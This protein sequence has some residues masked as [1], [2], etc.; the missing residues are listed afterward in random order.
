MHA[1]LCQRLQASK[2]P[3]FAVS[4]AASCLVHNANHASKEKFSK[5]NSFWHTLVVEGCAKKNLAWSQRK[6]MEACR[7]FKCV[8]LFG[9]AKCCFIFFI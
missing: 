2:I 9:R 1:G 3:F 7:N 5:E 4:R 6:K 8:E